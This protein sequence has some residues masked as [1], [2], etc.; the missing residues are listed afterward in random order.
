MDDVSHAENN[1]TLQFNSNKNSTNIPTLTTNIDNL[2]SA[3]MLS[4]NSMHHALQPSADYSASINGLDG[5]T[6][7]LDGR[8]KRSNFQIHTKP[9]VVT[10]HK[11]W[12]HCKYFKCHNCGKVYSTYARLRRHQI[13]H[14][15]DKRKPYKCVVCGNSFNQKQSL[16]RHYKAICSKAFDIKRSLNRRNKEA[17]VGLDLDCSVC[18]KSFSDKGALNRHELLHRNAVQFRCEICGELFHRNDDL[19]KHNETVHEDEFKKPECAICSR[20]FMK[21]STLNTHQLIRTQCTICKSA[22]QKCSLKKHYKEVHGMDS[23]K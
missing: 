1:S 18:N 21:Q 8:L 5:V 17:H 3:Q 19:K 4:P 12:T 23:F 6:D 22:L 11:W 9:S 16:R 7:D 20:T 10:Q 2:F 15:A 13:T 14:N